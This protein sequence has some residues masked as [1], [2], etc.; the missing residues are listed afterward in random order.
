MTQPVQRRDARRVILGGEARLR[1]HAGELAYEGIPLANL[2]HSGCL[3]LLPA[4]QARALV[5]NM[6]LED[7][8]ILYPGIYANPIRARVAWAMG[9]KDDTAAVG[10]QFLDMSSETRISLVSVIDAAILSASDNR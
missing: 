7:L 5:A 8:T 4:V 3:A 10:L 6:I 9:S 1:F 2:S